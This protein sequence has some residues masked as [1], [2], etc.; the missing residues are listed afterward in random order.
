GCETLPLSATEA[1]QAGLAKGFARV[2]VVCVAEDLG[3]ETG[4]SMPASEIASAAEAMLTGLTAIG[5]IAARAASRGT[6]LVWALRQGLDTGDSRVKDPL[7]G[8]VAGFA[9]TL[10]K[11]IEPA[12]TTLLDIEAESSADEAAH[13]VFRCGGL[14]GMYAW[15]RGALLR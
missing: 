9:Q 11:E 2:A 15:R 10:R 8:L 5:R 12:R 6:H 3:F 7:L 1:I 4:E 14:Q 13:I